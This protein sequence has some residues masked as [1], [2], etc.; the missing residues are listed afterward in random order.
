MAER[1]QGPVRVV[2]FLKEP[3]LGRVKTR[4]G[5]AIGAVEATRVYRVLSRR[6]LTTLRRDRR[7][8]LILAVTPDRLA[9][10]RTLPAGWPPDADRVGQG[11][12]SLGQRMA[13]VFRALGAGPVLLIGS[14]IPGLTANDVTF[15]AHALAG[16]D[17]VL[18][19]APDGGYWLIGMRHPRFAH[20]LEGKI[21][22]SSRDALADTRKSL[23]PQPR[24]RLIQ[25]RGDLDTADDYRAWRAGTL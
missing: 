12:G 23:G 15:A 17:V 20:A 10:A 2:V 5:R 25:L 19:P 3:V 13:R 9:Q 8:C 6:L 16:C 22:W 24:V 14:D 1:G 7:L 18:G 11:Q 4:L 21:R